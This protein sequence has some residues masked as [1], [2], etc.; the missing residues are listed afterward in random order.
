MAPLIRN[1]GTCWK[2]VVSSTASAALT[3]KKDASY[4]LNRR[5]GDPQRR[6]ECFE[7][8]D[9]LQTNTHVKVDSCMRHYFVP[10]FVAEMV[11]FGTCLVQI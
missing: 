8:E 6:Y 10:K 1:L 7:R 4:L 11:V 2:R 9:K 3:A 5:L